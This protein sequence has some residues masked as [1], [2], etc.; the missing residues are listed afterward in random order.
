MGRYGGPRGNLYVLLRVKDHP[1]LR[2]DEYDIIHDLDINFAQ[3]GLGDEVEIT[4]LDGPKSLRIPAGTQSGDVF[5]LKGLGVPY[6]RG[7]GRGDMLVRVQLV[8]PTR[9]SEEQRQI[10]LK[11]AESMG[12]TVTPQD[13]KGLFEKIRDALG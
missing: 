2:R 5:T 8:T 10:L 1:F 13:E 7:S 12:T 9:L 3:A 6:L 11:L 4:T